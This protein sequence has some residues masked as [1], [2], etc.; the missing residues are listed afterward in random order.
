MGYSISW[1]A[2]DS[3]NNA[4]LNERLS[5]VDTGDIGEYP[6]D[7]I[8]GLVL[9]NAWYLIVVDACE[10]ELVSDKTLEM[11]SSDNKVI[12]CSIE[13][14]C[15]FSSCSIWDNGSQIFSVSHQGD[16][17]IYNLSTTGKPPPAYDS[18]SK[19]YHDLQEVE[20][21]ENADVDMIFEIP[22]VL[23]QSFTG[24]KHDELITD[25]GDCEF[26]ILIS[27]KPVQKPWWNF[28]S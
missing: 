19:Q 5:L 26:T 14:H 9:P 15:M 18:I 8:V 28:W 20:G 23:A 11:L 22:S 3:N 4:A 24:F 27:N 21:G 17:S 16:D 10:H 25:L 7:P 1:L 6:D 13:E 2:I 12:A